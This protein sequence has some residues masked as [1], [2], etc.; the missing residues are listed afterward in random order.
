MTLPPNIQSDK[1]KPK[2]N[3]LNL[4]NLLAVA[5]RNSLLCEILSD[6]TV[7]C[8]IGS[9]LG[10]A[11]GLY[12]E[13]L[14][15]EKAREHYPSG[16]FTLTGDNGPTPFFLDLHRAPKDP[17]HWTDDT[18]HALLLVLGW[19]N[20][21][22]KETGVPPFPTQQDLASRLRVWVQQGLK[23][24]DTMPMGLGRLV[25]SVVGNKDFLE[26]PEKVARE[27]WVNTGK[28]I[29][30]NGSLMRTHP[31][32]IIGLWEEEEVVFEKAAELSRVTHVDLR[33]VLGCVLG[34]GLVKGLLK[35]EVT[36]ESDVDGVLER[37]LEWVKRACIEGL[38]EADIDGDLDMEE[39]NGY[40]YATETTGNLLEG[41]K[42]D[43][44][45]SIGYVYKTLGSGVM[46][47]R[48]A[49]RKMA[50]KGG[51]LLTRSTMF[52]ELITD[53]IMRGGDA[54]T[55]A[56]FAGALLGAYL[57]YGAL[58]DHWKHGLLH[59][60]WLMSKA[61]AMC[62]VLGVKDGSYVGKEDKDTWLDAGKGMI[63]QQEMEVKWMLLQQKAGQRM[64]VA[65]AKAEADAKARSKSSWTS[66]LPWQ[67]KDRG[68]S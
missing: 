30:P 38:K 58:P 51:S 33:C 5:S 46:L 42:L 31:L 61:E 39:L 67:G 13:F 32:G 8:I 68:R 50:E 28:T 65:V 26:E 63:E 60:E 12:T 49:M 41:L 6:K 59:G 24:L 40:I 16:K 45:T 44:P 36:T 62:Q 17:G 2:S 19:L 57:G 52:E 35:G 3:F 29:A 21:H 43:E 66:K 22:G 56:C 47:L 20:G 25:G 27:R 18:D 1:L 4:D 7:G 64:G 11:I 54:D 55:N 48:M 37:G 14:S 10:D 9:A 15:S 34:T 23:P 53:L